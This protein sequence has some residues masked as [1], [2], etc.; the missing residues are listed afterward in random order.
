MVTTDVELCN[1]ALSLLGESRIE[2]LTQDNERA[3]ICNL[4]YPQTRDEL[5]SMFQWPFAIKRESLAA[6]S[7]ANLTEYEYR[8]TLPSD[9]LRLVDMIDPVTYKILSGQRPIPYC[10]ERDG[11]PEYVGVK[12]QI[13]GNRLLTDQSPCII[14]Y[15]RRVVNP[16]LFPEL[17]V[18]TLV[19][20]VAAKIATRLSQNPQLAMQVS[21]LSGNAFVRAAAELNKMALTR[22][23][24]QINIA[25]IN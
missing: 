1:H 13:E 25:E 8:Y 18:S 9:Y 4:L 14:R 22:P 17:F 15:V 23:P 21:A 5:L 19:P 10:D 20:A 7:E 16:G 11:W 24:A 3:R 12:Y 6:V 2:N